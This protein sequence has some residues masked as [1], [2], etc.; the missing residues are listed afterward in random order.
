MK[1]SSLHGFLTMCSK[2]LRSVTR[3]SIAEF[4]YTPVSSYVESAALFMARSLSIQLTSTIQLRGC[5]AIGSGKG[6][7]VEISELMR[8]IWII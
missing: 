8:Q 7:T 3:L 1:Q 2:E 6:I 4:R 5:A